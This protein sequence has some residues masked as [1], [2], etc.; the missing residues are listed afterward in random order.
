MVMHMYAA[1]YVVALCSVKPAKEI[2][3]TCQKLQTIQAYFQ[4]VLCSKC[5][6]RIQYK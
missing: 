3:E 2:I 5:F 4:H 1:L 6:Y